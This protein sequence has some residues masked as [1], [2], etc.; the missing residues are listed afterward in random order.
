M[1]WRGR[2]S[3]IRNEWAGE[4]GPVLS[5]AGKV[6]KLRIRAQVV[7]E[8]DAKDFIEAA[9]HQQRIESFYGS[10]RAAYPA[11][12][13]TFQQV[14]PARGTPPQHGQVAD[15]PRRV[16]PYKQPVRV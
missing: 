6:G 8:F 1:D 13:F 12:T 3:C 10:V 2:S 15:Q 5:I 14:R 4:P 16:V 11:A 9:D 7:I